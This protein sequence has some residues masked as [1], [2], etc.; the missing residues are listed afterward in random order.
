MGLWP[1]T[2][3]GGWADRPVCN[4]NR[5]IHGVLADTLVPGVWP[6]FLMCLAASLRASSGEPL[7]INQDN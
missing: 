2:P 3:A 1:V 5:E 6:S 7:K 4:L